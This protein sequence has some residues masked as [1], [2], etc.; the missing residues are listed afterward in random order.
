[1][2][3]GYTMGTLLTPWDL[4]RGGKRDKQETRLLRLSVPQS[5][6]EPEDRQIGLWLMTFVQKCCAYN[7][8][9][10]AAGF[11]NSGPLAMVCYRKGKMKAIKKL[12]SW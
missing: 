4:T 3:W 11:A 12:F 1:M 9:L 5:L 2:M 7:T 8:K 10:A 6:C